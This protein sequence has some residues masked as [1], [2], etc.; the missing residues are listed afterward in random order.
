MIGRST[1]IASGKRVQAED[2]SRKRLCW[3]DRENGLE[4]PLRIG[5]AA[6]AASLHAGAKMIL[7]RAALHH[8][9]RYRTP[10]VRR[11]KSATLL[12]SSTSDGGW[13]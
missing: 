12:C 9:L 5:Q 7:D 8:V 10:L 3:V 11:M 6:R 4:M 1:R 2:V 13:T